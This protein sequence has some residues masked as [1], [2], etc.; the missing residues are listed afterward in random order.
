[1]EPVTFII[2]IGKNAFVIDAR[3]IN[4]SF[5]SLDSEHQLLIDVSMKTRH[6]TQGL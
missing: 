3:R 6:K 5:N 2:F 1:M 4:A